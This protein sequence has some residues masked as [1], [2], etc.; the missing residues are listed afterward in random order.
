V[1]AHLVAL[2]APARV[3]VGAR[4]PWDVIGSGVNLIFAAPSWQN[5]RDVAP[6]VTSI[7]RTNEEQA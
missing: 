1:V 6:D 2:V 5:D 4:L 7:A 3:F